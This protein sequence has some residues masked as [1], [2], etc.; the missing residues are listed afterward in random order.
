MYKWKSKLL[1]KTFAWEIVTEYL[2][3]AAITCWMLD[4]VFSLQ[5]T[6]TSRKMRKSFF[7]GKMSS[8]FLYDHQQFNN[9]KQNS[10]SVLIEFVSAHLKISHWLDIICLLNVSCNSTNDAWM[11]FTSGVRLILLENRSRQI[12]KYERKEVYHLL[13]NIIDSW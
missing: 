2:I 8:I 7:D 4:L 6:Q 13:C 10:T 1:K 11:F 3:I 9:N 12:F 5:K